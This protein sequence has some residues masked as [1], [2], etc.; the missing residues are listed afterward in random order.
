MTTEHDSGGP[1][2]WTGERYL[3]EIPGNIRLEHVHRY[4]LAKELAGGRRVLDSWR[5]PSPS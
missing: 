5:I 2:E 1:L 4:L 3:P